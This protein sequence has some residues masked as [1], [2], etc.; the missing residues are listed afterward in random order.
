ME[1]PSFARL[2]AFALGGALI[3]SFVGPVASFG[4]AAVFA[5]VGGVLTIARSVTGL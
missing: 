4:L 3:G 5:F 1:L 2:F